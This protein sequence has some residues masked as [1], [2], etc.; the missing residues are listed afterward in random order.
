MRDHS[1]NTPAQK[2][3]AA[4][5]RKTWVAPTLQVYDVAELTEVFGGGIGT[6]GP[7]YNITY[8]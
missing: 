3:E 7:L 8:S 4:D 6:D 1:E 2:T 5:G